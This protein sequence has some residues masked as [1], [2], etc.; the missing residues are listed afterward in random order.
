MKQKKVKP[1]PTKLL[2]KLRREAYWKLGVF[3]F[4]N[5]VWFTIRHIGTMF[6]NLTRNIG[7]RMAINISI[8]YSIGKMRC[9]TLLKERKNC[10]TTIAYRTFS[11]K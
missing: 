5:I 10:V 7:E 2:K 3:K 6:P 1:L 8:K 4:E 11:M 9:A